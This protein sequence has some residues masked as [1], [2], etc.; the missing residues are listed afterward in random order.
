MLS[1]LYYYQVL[2]AYSLSHLENYPFS[3][4]LTVDKRRACPLYQCKQSSAENAR[5][6]GKP[7]AK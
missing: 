1:R 7:M 6:P 3:T 4:R 2:Q 5:R